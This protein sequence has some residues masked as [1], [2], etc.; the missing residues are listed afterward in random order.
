MNYQQSEGVTVHV[1]QYVWS[2]LC[3]N[4]LRSILLALSKATARINSDMTFTTLDRSFC[5]TIIKESYRSVAVL[6]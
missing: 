5:V 6:S 3:R 4:E 1:I 2:V